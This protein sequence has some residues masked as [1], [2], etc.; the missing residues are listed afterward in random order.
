MGGM[1]RKGYQDGIQVITENSKHKIRAKHPG[2]INSKQ[3]QMTEAQGL[4]K[5]LR[6]KSFE[7]LGIRVSK[8]SALLNTGRTTFGSICENGL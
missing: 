7:H 1:G 5:G 8:L 3:T 6:A 4:N 2:G